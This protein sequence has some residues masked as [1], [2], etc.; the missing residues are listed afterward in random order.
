M[1]P[2]FFWVQQPWAQ[3]L[4]WTLLHFL[5]QGLALDLLASL[6]LALR[7]GADAR[8]RYGAACAFLLLMVAAPLLTFALLWPPAGVPGEP[9]ALL[10]S[11]GA[12]LGLESPGSL[13]QRLKVAMGPNLPWLLLG[14][15]AGVLL[16]SLRFLASWL[17]VQRLRHRTATPVPS[18]WHPVLS[19]LCR[20]LRLSRTVR[21]LQSAAVQVPTA[22]GW[23]RPMILLP[24]CALSG[25]APA[26]LEAILAHEL[27]HIRRGDFV[28]NLLQ[29]LVEVVLF[30]HPAVWWLSARIRTERELCCDDV[31]AGLCGDPLLLARALADLEALREPLSPSPTHLA[32]AANGGSLMHRIHHLLHPALP[33]TSGARATAL[34]VLAASLLGA[35]G[36]AL[37]DKTK[38]DSAPSK[39]TTQIQ[40]SEGARKLEVRLKGEVNLN[41]EAPEPVTIPGDGSFRVEEKKDGKRRAYT[42]T[43]G[44]ATYTVDG[45]EQALDQN[46]QDWL[47]SVVTEARKAQAAAPKPPRVDGARPHQERVIHELD[48]RER[49]LDQREQELER[50]GKELKSRFQA[51][52]P[53]ERAQV[54][55]E[56]EQLK[57]EAAT[58]NAE[59]ARFRAERDHLKA[60]LGH[61]A[62]REVRVEVIKR[63]G[64][65]PGTVILHQRG[66]GQ[67][68][69]EKRVR[70]RRDGEEEVLTEDLHS[71]PRDSED[72]RMEMAAI[73]AEL[74]AL[75]ARLNQLRQQLVTPPRPP[76]PPSPLKPL[77]PLKPTE[78]NQPPIPPPDSEAPMPPPPPPPPPAPKAPPA[79][80][81]P[82]VQPSR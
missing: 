26:Q 61:P 23:L 55:R 17:R 70:I 46:G 9:S 30:Y 16:L 29:S 33:L 5:W 20:E 36:V 35:A 65:G 6:F 7:R 38:G 25:L 27:A 72:A 63:R 64:D 56:V 47:R 59:G 57:A 19:R 14:W 80:P 82:P 74:K 77:K 32:L 76:K 49:A 44:K 67:G 28:V 10:G 69:V 43:K 60:E 12:V 45:R 24:A 78:P 3:A 50:R 39:Q 11:P 21:L 2:Y 15:A 22:L 42:A 8:T 1:T 54:E 34:A 37:Q 58:L 18:E 48:T 40:V 13:V 51:A 41:G 79:P 71:M 75:Q 31:A 68:S 62:D 66:P 73:Q 52:N 81:A 4:G 53:D